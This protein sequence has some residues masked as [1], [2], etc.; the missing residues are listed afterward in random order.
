M[1]VGSIPMIT[2]TQVRMIHTLASALHYDDWV[3]RIVLRDSFGVT[4]SKQLSYAQAAGFINDLENLAVEKGVWTK[5]EGNA[6]FNGLGH[7]LG[8]AA[9]AQLRKIEVLFRNVTR[10]K[11]ID[12]RKRGLRTFLKNKFHVSDIR[13]VTEE[14][15]SKIVKAL[16]E[17]QSR[18]ESKERGNGPETQASAQEGS[19]PSG[20]GQ[21]QPPGF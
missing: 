16:T 17:W 19:G 1:A 13:F 20:S 21:A 7:R 12:A 14:Q 8:M 4:S 5:T 18:Q 15:V 3:Y 11:D 2:G 6:A 9:P 10:I